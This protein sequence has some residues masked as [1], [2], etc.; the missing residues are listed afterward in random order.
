MLIYH[1]FVYCTI[2]KTHNIYCTRLCIVTID[3]LYKICYNVYSE[4]KENP[5]TERKDI[6][7]MKLKDLVNIEVDYDE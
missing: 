4:I 5:K 6:M 7:K 2:Y 3:I 1:I